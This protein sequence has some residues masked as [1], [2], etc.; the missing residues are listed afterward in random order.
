SFIA[1]TEDL[2]R[3]RSNSH[4]MA[5]HHD[6]HGHRY[7]PQDLIFEE[8]LPRLT[9][10]CLLRFKTVCKEWCFIIP[11]SQFA[12]SHMRM[13]ILH[14]TAN[15]STAAADWRFFVMKFPNDRAYVMI[16]S[17]RPRGCRWDEGFRRLKDLIVTKAG[18]RYI[19][20]TLGSSDGLLF[21]EACPRNSLLAYSKFYTCNPTLDVSFR[22]SMPKFVPN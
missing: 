21:I 13:H 22:L 17:P 12:K 15:S 2:A 20:S 7:L 6:H 3:R 1:K 9:V 18:N 11:S 19:F 4:S 8:I 14:V 16:G 10:K 5:S